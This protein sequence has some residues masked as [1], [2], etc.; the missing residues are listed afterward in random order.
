MSSV[1]CVLVISSNRYLK[2]A[3]LSTGFAV[4]S[5]YAVLVVLGNRLANPDVQ[6]IVCIDSAHLQKTNMPSGPFVFPWASPLEISD[7][8]S[9][10]S[11]NHGSI[12]VTASA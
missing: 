8:V 12:Y 6:L 2:Q 4:A 9:R 10:L 7:I 5:S 1:V 3:I 11:T